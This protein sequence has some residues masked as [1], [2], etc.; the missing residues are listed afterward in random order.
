MGL[1]FLEHFGGLEDVRVPGMVTYPLDEIVL[2]TLSGLLSGAEDWED[3]VTL[4]EAHLEWL[5]GYLPFHHGI[6]SAETYQRAFR[7]LDS[8]I[9]AARFVAWVASLAGRVE[10]IVAI[11]GK[12]SRGSK[13]DVSGSGALHMLSAFAHESGLVIGQKATYGKGHEIT[14]IPELLAVLALEG[15]VVTIDAIGAQR[16]IV[17]TILAKGADY[18]I[19]LKGNQG[20][21][22]EDVALFCKEESAEVAWDC[23]STTD[24]GHG[25]IEE[26]ACLATSDIGWLQARHHWPGLRSIAQVTAQR[27]DKKNGETTKETR[28]FISSLPADAMRLLTTVRAHWSIENALHWSLDVTFA[29]DAN[30]TRKD[31]AAANLATLRHAAFNLLK[32]SKRKGSLKTKRLKAA[33][34]N[35]YRAELINSS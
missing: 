5:R 19:A 32:R 15:T 8:D 16:G 3:I 14:A 26:R 24:G 22:H 27:T 10:G 9:L 11:D 6:A 20:T 34:H 18:V 33:L 1:L 17:E 25:R 29:D 23:A 13:K 31:H 4:G 30:R 35:N 28:L 21:L 2:S 7:S 12:T